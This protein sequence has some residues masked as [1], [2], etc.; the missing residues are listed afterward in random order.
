MTVKIQG[1]EA[2]C[3]FVEYGNLLE[4]STDGYEPF[5]MFRRSTK[6]YAWSEGTPQ[7]SA[8]QSIDYVT[9]ILVKLVHEGVWSGDESL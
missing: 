3:G 8:Q 4:V 2:D 1:Q 6:Y 7:S 5:Q 9:D